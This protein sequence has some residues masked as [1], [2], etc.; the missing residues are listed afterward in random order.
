MKKWMAFIIFVLLLILLSVTGTYSEDCNSISPAALRL[1]AE[2]TIDPCSIC[3]KKLQKQAYAI[4]SRELIPGK[5][6][7]FTNTCPLAKTNDCQDNELIIKNN[8]YP[9]KIIIN[10]TEAAMPKVLYKFFSQDKHIVGIAPD[11]YTS[12]SIQNMYQTLK[13]DS[14]VEARLEIISYHYS[15]CPS[16][17]YLHDRNALIIFCKILSM[18]QLQ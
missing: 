14:P 13:M 3:Q 2:S 4:V 10:G 17:L 5:K 12:N 18:K 8:E 11:D 1:L 6:L 9:K 15:D 16:A 7:T